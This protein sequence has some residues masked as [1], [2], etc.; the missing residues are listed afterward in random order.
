MAGDNPHHM[1]LIQIIPAQ[2]HQFIT[3]GYDR[4]LAHWEILPGGR[5][6]ECLGCIHTLGS[7]VNHLEIV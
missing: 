7:V 4:T 1:S 5:Y 6:L 3:V 2:K